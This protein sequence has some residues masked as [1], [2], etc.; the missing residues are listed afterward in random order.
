MVLA[1]HF[2]AQL[3]LEEVWIGFGAGKSFREMPIHIIVRSLG[4][5]VSYAMPFFHSYTGCDITSAMFGIGKKSAWKIYM[6]SVSTL[7]HYLLC[8]A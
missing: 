5:Q 1:I 7:H 4:P 3:E 8:F 2:F 6:A